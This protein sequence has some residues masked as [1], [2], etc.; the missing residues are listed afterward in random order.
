V[1]AAPLA[2]VQEQWATYRGNIGAFLALTVLD[3]SFPPKPG[4]DSLALRQ[5]VTDGS[6]LLLENTEALIGSIFIENERA[7][8]QALRNMYGLLLLDGLMLLA[9]FGAA[10]RQ[11]IKPLRELFHHCQQ[12][13]MGNYGSRVA[14]RS[15]DEIG[16]LALAFNDS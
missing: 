2:A 10:R 15:S 11:M 8:S 3:E 5:R 1:H 6:V 12:L 7:Q 9:A 4:L 14:Y 13:A 16:Q